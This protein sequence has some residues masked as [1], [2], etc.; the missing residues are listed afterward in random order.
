MQFSQI[1][2]IQQFNIL[3]YNILCNYLYS[4]LLLFW[5]GGTFLASQMTFNWSNQ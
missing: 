1:I 5:T 2:N 3:D 4:S